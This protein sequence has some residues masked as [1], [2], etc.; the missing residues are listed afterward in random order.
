MKIVSLLYGENEWAKK[1]E[2]WLKETLKFYKEDEIIIMID[3]VEYKDIHKHTYMLDKNLVY[4][5]LTAKHDYILC[6][7]YKSQCWIA[8]QEPCVFVNANCILKTRLP[9]WDDDII[10]ICR[11][12][13]KEDRDHVKC[14]LFYFDKDYHSEYVCILNSM[15]R[16]ISL[17]LED[18]WML[19]ELAFSELCNKHDT[20]YLPLNY[21][22]P[23]CLRPYP[24]DVKS[25][26]LM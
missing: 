9:D 1:L 26:H 16:D 3:R 18:V 7:Y 11:H 22:W 25:L 21:C 2:S 8:A 23:D 5:P 14:S 12:T 15:I 6:D 10:R 17:C 19:G 24:K 20:E 13:E 4:L